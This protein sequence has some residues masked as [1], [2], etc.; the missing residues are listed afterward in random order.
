MIWQAIIS[1]IIGGGLISS[2]IALLTLLQVKKTNTLEAF[3]KCL[4][5]YLKIMD[6][7]SIA[8]K[9]KNFYSYLDYYRALFDLQ[10]SEYQMWLRDTIPDGPYRVWLGLR[11]GQYC[12]ESLELNDCVEGVAD[13][14]SYRLVW[15]RLLSKN[16]FEEKDPFR[17]HMELVHEGNLDDAMNQKYEKYKFSIFKKIRKRI[18]N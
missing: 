1:G 3:F 5:G 12:E 15:E 7:R 16:Y 10:W 14:I 6:Y 17:A 2:I 13:T 9:E 11:Y 18:N 8:I 4:E